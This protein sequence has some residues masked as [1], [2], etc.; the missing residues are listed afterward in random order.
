M[1]EKKRSDVPVATG[2]DFGVKIDPAHPLGGRGGGHPINLVFESLG[3][4]QQFYSRF[5]VELVRLL[6]AEAGDQRRFATGIPKPTMPT[7]IY[8]EMQ[9]VD[10]KPVED[11][12]EKAIAE[13]RSIPEPAVEV[14]AKVESWRDRA[15]LI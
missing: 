6:M 13:L 8:H 10:P 14:E 7:P 9:P 15:P 2:L 5:G 4:A 12:F 3:E 11:L 1:S